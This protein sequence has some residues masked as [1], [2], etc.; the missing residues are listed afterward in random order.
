MNEK[1]YTKKF[2]FTVSQAVSNSIFKPEKLGGEDIGIKGCWNN[3]A[4]RR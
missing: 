1:L 3:I 4:I 2:A